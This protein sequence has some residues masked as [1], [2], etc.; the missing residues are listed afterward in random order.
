MSDLWRYPEVVAVSDLIN[1]TKTCPVS[2]PEPSRD[3]KHLS[4]CSREHDALIRGFP[5]PGI[6]LRMTPRVWV[7]YASSATK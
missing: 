2:Q 4:V 6:P 7:Y 3:V 5:V 1:G